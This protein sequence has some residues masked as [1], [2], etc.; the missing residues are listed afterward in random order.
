[1]SDIT[2]A[3]REPASQPPAG[4]D[5][6]IAAITTFLA[7]RDPRVLE[8]IRACLEQEI[9]AAGPRALI[10]LAR[11]LSE[12]ATEWAYYPPDPLARR[13][14]HVIADRLLEPG[15][16]LTGYEHAVAVAGRPVVILANHLSYSDANLLEILLYRQGG[17]ALG[18]RLT[19]VAGPKVYSDTKRRFS[20]LCFGSIRVPQSSALS[21]EEAVMTARDVA[22]A[23][24]QSINAALDRLR[25]NDALLLFAE[26]TRS[27]TSG[28]QPLLTGVTRYLTV[29]GTWILPVGIVGTEALF[30]IGQDELHP[31]E[32]VARIGPAIPVEA[33]E[34]VSNGDSR[35]LMDAVGVAVAE[36]LP[37]S[38]QGVYGETGEGLDAA[39]LVLS[40][41]RGEAVDTQI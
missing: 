30:P 29:P 41:A 22:R 33:L 37:P 2:T 16:T 38:Y 15:S 24:R 1:M 36:L 14:H 18:D 26:G 19:T 32:I 9:H 7:G 40:R 5:K 10:Q 31:V 13:I 34:A 11:R 39:R 3:A 6:L 27:R 8:D 25:Q 12:P 23:A 20:S 17:S 4:R 21:S 35:L 28:M